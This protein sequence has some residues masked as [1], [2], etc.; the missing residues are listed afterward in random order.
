MSA[1]RAHDWIVAASS[2]H[3][4]WQAA[5]R[6]HSALECVAGRRPVVRMGWHGD[7][8]FMIEHLFQLILLYHSDYFFDMVLLYHLKHLNYK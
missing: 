3:N 6:G 5:A 2:G 1:T 8:W 7:M 4:V